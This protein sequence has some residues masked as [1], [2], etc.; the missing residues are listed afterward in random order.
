MPVFDFDSTAIPHRKQTA[1]RKTHEPNIAKILIRMVR[2]DFDIE[3]FCFQLVCVR[4]AVENP[5]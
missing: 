1:E 5:E 3:C 2:V 4:D